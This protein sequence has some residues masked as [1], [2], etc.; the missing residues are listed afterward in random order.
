MLI[1]ASYINLSGK[2]LYTA[3]ILSDD[4]DNMDRRVFAE[5]VK[6]LQALGSDE[7]SVKP[8]GNGTEFY[9]IS[10][11]RVD[12][13]KLTVKEQL[14]EEEAFIS[15]KKIQKA[16]QAI[17]STDI[18][19]RVNSKT[20]HI[21]DDRQD[22]EIGNRDVSLAP[23]PIAIK[24]NTKHTVVAP[25]EDIQM[26][27]RMSNKTC[28]SFKFTI[29]PMEIVFYCVN[30]DGD[31]VNLTLV[32]D[33]L[34]ELVTNKTVSATY[35]V[36]RFHQF[37]KNIKDLFVR[38]SININSPLVLSVDNEYFSLDYALAPVVDEK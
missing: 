22:F 12:A 8:S 9:T 17:N 21:S 11:D 34:R 32:A 31:E 18:N 35:D 6:I 23:K 4:G 7:V 26:F 37:I 13:L 38:L 36:A 16:L 2:S 1:Y 29:D 30:D 14:A 24:A 15:L 20:T 27:A 25:T 28:S 19:I 33:Q 3:S 5:V 10:S